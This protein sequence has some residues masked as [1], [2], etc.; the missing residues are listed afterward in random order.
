MKENKPSLL[1][2]LKAKL[3]DYDTEKQKKIEKQSTKLLIRLYNKINTFDCYNAGNSDIY[4]FE[5]LCKNFYPK[6]E[7]DDLRRSKAYSDFLAKLKSKYSGLDN[8]EF[9]IKILRE[10]KCAVAFYI[11]FNKKSYK[12]TLRKL[13]KLTTYPDGTSDNS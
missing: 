3:K 10:Q 12:V 9:D 13:S 4:C 6:V 7:I 8:A 2:C 1:Q 11:I 5:I